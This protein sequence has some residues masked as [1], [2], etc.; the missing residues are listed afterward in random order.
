MLI[1]IE[2]LHKNFGALE[3]LKNIHFKIE[4]NDKIGLIGVNGA[5]KTTLL[6]ILTGEMDYDGGLVTRK[7]GITI[8]YLKQN[9]GLDSSRT[10]LEEMKTVFSDL[11]Y[12]Q[13]EL[14]RVYDA[15][16][17]VQDQ[18]TAEYK[19]LS[20]RLAK[21]QT[22]FEQREGYQIEVKI[23]TVLTGMGFQEKD[24]NTVISTL[25]GGE[26]TR[27]ALCKILLEAPDLLVL[28]EPTNHLDFKALTWLEEYLKSYKGALVMVSHDRYFLDALVTEICELRKNELIRYPGNYTKYKLLKQ[29][30]L[31]FL[32]KEYQ[33]Q[34]Q[35]IAS[36]QDYIA[37]NKVRASTAKSAH[38]RERML[39]HMELIE[40]PDDY[41]KTAKIRFDYD[42]EPVKDVLQ[43]EDLRLTV[44]DG[45]VLSEHIN[46]K[47][48]RG[49]KIAFIGANGVGKST[50]LKAILGK[51]PYKEGKI[52]IG[53]NVRLSYFE[54]E[55]DELDMEKCPF[56]ELHD[57]YPQMF[58]QTIRTAL[59]CVLLTGD[60][61]F[62]KIKSLSG[63]E[64]AKLK[65]AAMVLKKGNV[66][67]LDEPTNHLDLNTKEII[68]QALQAYQGTILMVSHDRYLLKNVPTHIVEM[69][70]S[71]MFFYQGKY[72]TYL[73]KK[74]EIIP[75]KKAVPKKTDTAYFRS[76]EERAN[77]VKRKNQ[78]K[79]TE[80]AIAKLEEE[81]VILEAEINSGEV[82]SDYAVLTEKC[83]RME[84]CK[85]QL[86]QLYE[87][88]MTFQ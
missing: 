43:V 15:I 22:G 25:S 37:K 72:E 30:R 88:W 83:N 59:G 52:S 70:G 76:K 5:G 26:K 49:D 42:Y 77:E 47:V 58:E 82:A 13:Q 61:V 67:V 71:D 62:K 17:Q 12:M 29:E 16:A 23:N 60:N 46:F 32:E 44:G 8:G 81:I 50:L 7:N 48:F 54:Q 38:S 74:R 66:L 33:K 14:K 79:K 45:I 24:R 64:K 1:Q 11:L 39:E 3:V 9:S 65:F 69:T 85:N 40:K 10:I 18:N 80:S 41:D 19:E 78:L 86:N 87:D 4:D 73:Q 34:Q 31:E 6:N 63:G 75:E 84:E 36:L 53:R 68:D 27:L 28:D 55:N 35:E 2:D 51:H 21:L 57:R 56:E 20:A